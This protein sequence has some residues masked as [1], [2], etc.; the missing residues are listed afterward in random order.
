MFLYDQIEQA[1]TYNAYK[2]LPSYIPENINPAFELRPY[3]KA[4]FQS[5]ITYYETEALR[6]KPSQTLFH[7][8]TGSGK[9]LIMAGLM[10]YLY[11]KGYRKFLFFVNLTNIVEKTKDNFLNSRNA[12][13]LFNKNITINGE[14]VVIKKVENFQYFDSNAINICFTTTQGLHFDMLLQKKIQ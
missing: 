8:A 3:Q 13:Y 7:M 4:A 9:T 6:Q 11:K 1:K 10:L 12:K 14:K 2:E 5:Y